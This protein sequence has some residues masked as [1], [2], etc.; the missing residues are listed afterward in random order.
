MISLTHITQLIGQYVFEEM[1]GNQD[2]FYSLDIHEIADQKRYL[3]FDNQLDHVMDDAPTII[4]HQI[5]Y[6]GEGSPRA[7]DGLPDLLL[8]MSCWDTFHNIS[9]LLRGLSK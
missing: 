4:Q 5:A 9:N 7:G 8:E 2:L 6:M 3:Y 1:F